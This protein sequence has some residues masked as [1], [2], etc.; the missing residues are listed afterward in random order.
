MPSGSETTAMASGRL[1]NIHTV[2]NICLP[3]YRAAIAP[4]SGPSRETRIL[5]RVAA[6]RTS[7]LGARPTPPGK[8]GVFF[9]SCLERA[10]PT[11][12]LSRRKKWLLARRK[13]LLPVTYFHAIFVL[14]TPLEPLSLQNRRLLGNTIIS[15]AAKSILSISEED[16]RAKP[17]LVAFFDTA[18]KTLMSHTHVHFLGTAGGLTPS[19]EWKAYNKGVFPSADAVGRIFRAHM[20]SALLL[21]LRTG[22]LILEGN[23]RTLQAGSN[24][25]SLLLA[26]PDDKWR[27][28]I[29][30]AAGG[31]ESILKYFS[32]STSPFLFGDNYLL[33]RD[34]I[35]FEARPD[36][37]TCGGTVNLTPVEFIRRSLLQVLPRGF[38][39]TRCFGTFAGPHRTRNI[40]M[41]RSGF[42]LTPLTFPPTPKHKR[43]K[44][45]YS[46]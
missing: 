40:A 21:A 30:H 18:S 9:R 37:T 7:T 25:R 10:C 32:K 17:A 36:D 6:C 46:T 8:T 15:A 13:E 43:R 29:I 5:E 42:G 20:L 45:R 11:C 35:S 16:L 1:T 12:P 2:F 26:I 33:A 24:L 28:E 34:R 19:G 14:P 39:R 22:D 27:P 44:R 4:A 23:L 31:P 3:Q 38:C 41:A